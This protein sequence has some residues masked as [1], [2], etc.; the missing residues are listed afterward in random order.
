MFKCAMLKGKKLQNKATLKRVILGLW[1]S[2]VC[3]KKY[4]LCV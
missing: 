1:H 2:K 4:V 3:V